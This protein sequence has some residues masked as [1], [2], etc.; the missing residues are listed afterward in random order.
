M[1]REDWR[2]PDPRDDFGQADY[3]SD[4][5]YDPRR[6]TGYRAAD[7][8]EH[9]EDYGQADYSEDYRFDP[10]SGRAYRRH[11]DD[12]PPLDRRDPRAFART[13]ESPERT[14]PHERRTFGREP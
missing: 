4:Y 13:D 1:P 6:R 9:G 5:A 7:E 10:D 12:E 2:R 8:V 11:S 14:D 3:S